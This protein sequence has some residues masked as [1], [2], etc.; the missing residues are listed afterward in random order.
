MFR[1]DPFSLRDAAR[2]L[3]AGWLCVALLPA[4][5]GMAQTRTDAA[6]RAA[7]G[8]LG[9]YRQMLADAV[10]ATFKKARSLSAFQAGLLR[11]S[12]APQPGDYAV[13]LQTIENGRIAYFAAFITA[14]RVET[15]RRAVGVDR[16]WMETS[17]SVLP[18]PRP[19]KRKRP[20]E[21]HPAQ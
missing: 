10:A 19:P 9:P 4:H 13:C 3:I 2:A 15:I 12:R 17:Y 6:P 16:C 7:A 20:W 14:G 8:E 18:A 11:V 1:F 5:A 21:I